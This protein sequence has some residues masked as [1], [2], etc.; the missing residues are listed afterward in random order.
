M[1]KSEPQLGNYR[2]HRLLGKGGFAEIYLGEHVYLQTKVAIKVLRVAPVATSEELEQ[3][4]IEARTIAQLQHPHIIKILDFNVQNEIPYLVMEYA[5]NGSLTARCPEKTVM[6]L[7][8]VNRCVRQ[9]ASALQLAHDHNIVHCD[10]KPDNILLDKN[11]RLLLS[12]FGI[13]V[14]L[15]SNLKTQEAIG[16]MQYMA[17]EQFFGKPVPASDQYGLAI[18][19]YRLLCG[20]LPFTGKNPHEL[21]HAH[22]RVPPPPPRDFN[23]KIPPDVEQVLLIALAKDAK[24]RFA[25]VS[26]F[27]KAFEQAMQP[28][29]PARPTKVFEIP[30]ADKPQI[31]PAPADSEPQMLLPS[32]S[33]LLPLSPPAEKQATPQ[34]YPPV[35]APASQLARIPYLDAPSIAPPREAPLSPPA[36]SAPEPV[37]SLPRAQ[38]FTYSN[39]LSWV[40]TVAW[41]PHG[42]WLA[43]GSWDNTVHVWDTT[44]K[45][46]LVYEEHKQPVKSVCWSPDGTY[47]A[48]GSWDNTVRIWEASTG[49]T[50][51]GKFDHEAQLE[52]VAWSPD[53]AYIASAGH[54]GV[55][56]VWN[57]SKKRAIFTYKGHGGPVWSVA[58]SPDSKYIVTASH[59][60]TAQVWEVLTG[61]LLLTYY[62]HR[63]P[64]TA[65]AWAS[66]GSIVASSD[67]KGTVYLWNIPDGSTLYH[68]Q[69]DTGAVKTLSWSPTGLCLASAVKDVQVW[70]MADPPPARPAFIYQGHENW[71]NAVAWSPDGC[72]IASAS[73]DKTVQLW[74]VDRI[75]AS[76][77]GGRH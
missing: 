77:K 5:P 55:A 35:D 46:L 19:A 61:K 50:L 8:S 7:K 20:R 60:K 17:P 64:V 62:N 48:S 34:S 49:E 44:G 15:H 24:Y 40:S 47:I 13:A 25:S 58:W 52:S 51:S 65:A 54:D 39:H 16:T 6:E 3:F 12:D 26:A 53:G 59:D 32:L 73:D 70:N 36:L 2:L 38:P 37:H 14:V 10:V 23:P 76:S 28:K 18:V 74:D 75:T 33:S 4:L 63:H 66:N 68:Y 30:A 42:R 27:A 31:S 29:R 41:S 67:Q 11:D 21:F 71:V 57:L 43:S 1:M 9:V 56:K 69:D 72:A 22:T 45:T